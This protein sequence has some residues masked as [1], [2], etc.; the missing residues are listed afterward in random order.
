MQEASTSAD[1]YFDK[2]SNRMFKFLSFF[3]RMMPV[4]FD[5]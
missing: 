2:L 1:G 5:G 4:I 3:K